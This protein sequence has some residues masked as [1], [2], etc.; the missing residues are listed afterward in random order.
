MTRAAVVDRDVVLVRGADAATYLQGQ[1]S[2]D[3][4]ALEVGASAF[5]LLLQPQGKVDAWLR[6]TRIAEDAFALDV[7]AGWGEHV[8]ARLRRF[9]LRVKVEL[10]AVDWPVTAVVDGDTDVPLGAWKVVPELGGDGFDLLNASA[11]EGDVDYEDLRV[12]AAVPRMGRELDESTIPAS[13]G[14]V[15]RSVSWTKGCYTGQELVARIDSRGDK[16]PTK[17]RRVTGDVPAGATLHLGDREVGHVT[18]VGSGVALAYVRREVEP[19]ADVVARWAGGE[20]TVRIE[21]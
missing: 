7:D 17:L 4:A 3:I 20:T 9:L 8:L 14:I 19:P 18:S 12:R 6:V 16:V 1:L 5:S 13:A 15:D 11:P 2:Q 21:P 10:E